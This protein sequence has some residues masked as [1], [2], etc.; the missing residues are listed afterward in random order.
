MTANK[1]I[2]LVLT[3]TFSACLLLSC[4]QPQTTGY[5]PEPWKYRKTLNRAFKPIAATDLQLEMVSKR[6]SFLAGESV[7]LTFRLTNRSERTVNIPEWMMAGSDNLK[8]YYRPE[9]IDPENTPFKAGDWKCIQ[10]QLAVVPARCELT[11]NPRNS[12]LITLKVPFIKTLP[13]PE[14]TLRF[15]I[16]AAT[17]LK[18]LDLKSLPVTITVK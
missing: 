15:Q 12:V 8:L 5:S 3:A 2:A 10:A 11:L 13:P 16:V 6:L 18:S 9:K 7:E 4:S 17:N 1:A 14:K